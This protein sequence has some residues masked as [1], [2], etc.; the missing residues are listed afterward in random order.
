MSKSLYPKSPIL[1]V[2]DEE[3]FLLSAEMAL[4]AE[5]INNLETCSNSARV[6]DL[7]AVETYSVVVLDLIMPEIGGLEL[8]MQIRERYPN[9]IVILLTAINEVETVVTCMQSG[10]FDYILKPVDRQRL[11]TTVRKAI[12]YHDIRQQNESLLHY[13]SSDELQHP[14]KFESIVT[15]N[16]DMMKLFQYMEAISRFP[17]PILITGDTGV[18]KELFAE[19]IHE[20]SGRAGEFVAVNVAGLDDHLFSD[21]LF[22][23]IRGAFT[24]AERERKGL[25]EKATDGTLFLDEIG[26]LR[27]ESQVKL[28][29]LLS[30]KSTYYP[31]GSDTPK[32]S[33]ARVV[34]ATNADLD[35]LQK[36]GIF[37]TDLFYRLT[38]H[39]IKIPP[40]AKRKDDLPSLLEHLFLKAAKMMGKRKPAIPDELVTLLENYNFPG[41]IRE[42]ESM[43]NDAMGRYQGGRLALDAFREKIFGDTD[44]PAVPDEPELSTENGTLQF[45]ED[46]PSIKAWEQ[47]LIDEALR[48]TSNNQRQAAELLGIS[49]RA[50]NNRL[51]RGKQNN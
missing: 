20:L 12:E 21:T 40:L 24:G 44:G 15:Q 31:I 28:L 37:R 42:L 30:D 23:H 27:P 46:L 22:G 9:Q 36:D 48:R 16:N 51:S 18:G 8:L 38:T 50:L 5:G 25:I 32:I 1:M 41:N 6:M 33:K 34:C 10:A 13:L 7:L 26:D 29:R 17:L 19:T 2:D 14:A 43:V 39:Q 4:T 47:A 49:R 3:Q 45:P 11:A 35:Q